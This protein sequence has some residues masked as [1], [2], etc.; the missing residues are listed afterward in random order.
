MSDHVEWSELEAVWKDGDE[1]PAVESPAKPGVAWDVGALPGGLD[2]LAMVLA[3]RRRG[4]LR[5]VAVEGVLTLGLLAYT[6]WLLTV[7]EGG[8]VGIV[9]GALWA[10]WAIASGFAWWNR[11]GQWQRTAASTEEFLRLSMTWARR[12]QR[13]AVFTVVFLMGQVLAAWAL[14]GAEALAGTWTLYA[15]VLFGLY[16]GW[17]LWY[18]RRAT[19][20]FHT[21]KA[22]LD[23]SE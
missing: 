18:Y 16:G 12:K 3:A 9:L 7:G 14:F 21:F 2:G 17:A 10:S 1:G 5:V 4:M 11:R 20:D 22:L 19:R 13:V 8:S 15:I 6:V 23:G